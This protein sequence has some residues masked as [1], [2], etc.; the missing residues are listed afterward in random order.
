MTHSAG[1]NSIAANKIGH[2]SDAAIDIASRMR[3][4]RRHLYVEFPVDAL[5]EVSLFP[6]SKSS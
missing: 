2:I 1:A 6:K 5:F 4:A 3:L